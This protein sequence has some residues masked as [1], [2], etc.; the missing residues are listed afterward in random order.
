MEFGSSEYKHDDG[1]FRA[2]FPPVTDCND[3]TM[4]KVFLVASVTSFSGKRTTGSILSQ[5]T[6]IY[7]GGDTQQKEHG[8]RS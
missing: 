2:V 3:V 7:K 5:R 6:N 8:S 4:E 1:F